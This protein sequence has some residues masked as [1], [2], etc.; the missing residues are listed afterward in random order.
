MNQTF[1]PVTDFDWVEERGA[2][3]CKDR[4]S[5][6]RQMILRRLLAPNARASFARGLGGLI[7]LQV[8]TQAS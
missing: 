1:A 5:D 6:C 4:K 3:S 2:G 8:H 7:P